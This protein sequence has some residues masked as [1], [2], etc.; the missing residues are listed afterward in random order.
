M[1]VRYSGIKFPN[2]PFCDYSKEG[3]RIGKFERCSD[4]FANNALTDACIG[5]NRWRQ[6]YKNFFATPKRK[7]AILTGKK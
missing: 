3:N 2:R 7:I 4:C 6:F 5:T 1:L